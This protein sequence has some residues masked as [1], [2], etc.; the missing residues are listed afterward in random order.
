M[1]FV[2]LL[3]PDR[4]TGRNLSYREDHHCDK[5]SVAFLATEC[6]FCADEL[7]HEAREKVAEEMRPAEKLI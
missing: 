4:V 2:S 6:S 5:R 7:L 1:N 3:F